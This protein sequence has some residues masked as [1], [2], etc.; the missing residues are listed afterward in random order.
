MPVIA[1]FYGIVIRMYSR[2]HGVAHFHAI[3]G[4][5]SGVFAIDTLDMIEGSLPRRAQ[6]M[7]REWAT[8]NQSALL[9]I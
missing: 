1:R 9:E 3:Y 2:E 8:R 5:F 6:K 4:N 7:V